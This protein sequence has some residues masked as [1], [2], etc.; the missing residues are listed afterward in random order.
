MKKIYFILTLIFISQLNIHSQ[1]A[2]EVLDK[3][4]SL[5][6]TNKGLSTEFAITNDDGSKFEGT[7]SLKNKMF[8]INTRLANIWFDGK[9]QWTHII[10]NKEVNIS[11]PTANELQAINPYNFINL[12]KRGYKYSIN[13][14]AN[15]H[16][17]HLIATD[18]TNPVKELYLTISKNSY[19]PKNIRLNRNSK[20]SKINLW[21]FKN[22]N[23]DDSYF[24]FDKTKNPDVE[25]ID[26]R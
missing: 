24:R 23:Y 12:Y 1:S 20:W 7:I 17:V 22:I 5:L 26:L 15:T 4:A 8:Y 9:T 11:T 25:I 6:S 18:S 19:I 2:K 14:K 13:S 21:N 16:I 10:D 3:T